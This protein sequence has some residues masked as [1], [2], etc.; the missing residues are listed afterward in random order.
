M[1]VSR[2][3]LRHTAAVAVAVTVL[4][5]MAAVVSTA[6]GSRHTSKPAR[7]RAPVIVRVGGGF[8]WV[9]GAVGAAAGFGLTLVATGA[10]LELRARVPLMRR[11][12]RSTLHSTTEGGSP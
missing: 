10:L 4:F 5:G 11:G 7:S 9:D 12:S 8:N 2:D 3:R 6:S 1:N